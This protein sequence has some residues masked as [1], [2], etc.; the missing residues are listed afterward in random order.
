MTYRLRS[1]LG[2]AICHSVMAFILVTP[3]MAY[4]FRWTYG[5]GSNPP[6][7]LEATVHL[8]NTNFCHWNS[9]Q[10]ACNSM[11]QE[12]SQGAGL[13]S[14]IAKPVTPTE[15][16][17]IYWCSYTFFVD[18]EESAPSEL[19]IVWAEEVGVA[20][21]CSTEVNGPYGSCP[22]G[23]WK[24][25]LSMPDGQGGYTEIPAGIYVE[26]RPAGGYFT[27]MQ[28][29]I[30][31]GLNS[32]R[33]KT[34]ANVKA[35][36]SDVE[37]LYPETNC[38]NGLISPDVDPNNDCTAQVH[39]V[40]PRVEG[41]LSCPCGTSSHKNAL[42]ISRKLNI[43]LSNKEPLPAFLAAVAAV[44]PYTCS[45]AITPYSNDGDMNS[46]NPLIDP[47]RRV[48]RPVASM[49]EEDGPSLI[50]KGLLPPPP[51]S[52]KPKPRADQPKIILLP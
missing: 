39:H 26:E 40:V 19:S 48:V 14:L 7:C 47:D 13:G 4:C 2:R 9:A 37:G 5:H 43:Q 24:T 3:A 44:S 16:P 42:L 23:Y 18:N 49:P 17:L 22:D 20:T 8:P 35:L 15:D 30:I 31:R 50:P 46:D 1:V 25:L 41:E 33:H 6:D 51:P 32:L 38:P 21:W 12:H 34:P 29:R 28:R 10:E 27:K 45:D 11:V 52:P 36:K